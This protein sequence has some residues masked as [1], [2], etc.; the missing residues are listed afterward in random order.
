[1]RGEGGVIQPQQIRTSDDI[2]NKGYSIQGLLVSEQI[3]PTI[4]D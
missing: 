1:V 3:T 2:A 4:L